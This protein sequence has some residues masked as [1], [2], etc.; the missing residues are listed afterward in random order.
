MVLQRS[1]NVIEAEWEDPFTGVEKDNILPMLE[2][3]LG[4]LIRFR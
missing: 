3:E 2:I 1:G 4:V